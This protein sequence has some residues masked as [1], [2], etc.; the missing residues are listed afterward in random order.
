[1]KRRGVSLKLKIMAGVGGL[2]LAF[3]VTVMGN[4]HYGLSRMLKEELTRRGVTVAHI[5]VGPTEESILMNDQFALYQLFR[6]TMRS[7]DDVRYIYVLGAA[8]DIQAHTFPGGIPKGLAQVNPLSGPTAGGV[9][10][11]RISTEEGHI[12]D[13]ASPL[14]GGRLGSIHVGMTEQSVRRRIAR[15]ILEWGVGAALMLI[16]GLAVAYGLTVKLAQRFSHLVD[17]ARAVGEGNLEVQ[18][19]DEHGD[20]VG[21]L[22]GALNL[23]IGDLKRSQSSLIRSGKLAAIGELSSSV[24]HEINNPLN[25]MAICTQS[26]LDRAKSPALLACA[27]FEDFPEYLK[28]VNDEI[29]RCKTITDGLLDFARHREPRHGSVDLDELIGNTIPLVAHRAK[30]MGQS[31]VFV[32]SS[33]PVRAKAD[34]DQIK[35][36]VLNILINALDHNSPDGEVRIWAERSGSDASVSVQDNGV[37]ILQENISKV[38]EPFF[39]TK[40]AGKGTGLGL[41]ICQKIIDSHHGRIGV[42]SRGGQGSTFTFSIP[43]DDREVSSDA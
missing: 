17:V 36:V 28:T 15:V 8:G 22:S 5:L 32:P 7:Y 12:Q 19:Q 37:G 43:L 34:A 23:M 42:T 9:H 33:R 31:I 41:A 30:Q 10:A 20:E 18:A 25:T 21:R 26:L 11:R 1:M 2:V 39:T 6:Q 29:F 38:F 40:S 35:Q 14:L 3:G 16:F 13:I 27:D 4:I 24:A